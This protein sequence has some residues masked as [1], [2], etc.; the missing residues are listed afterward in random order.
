LNIDTRTHD[1]H[2]FAPCAL[3]SIDPVPMSDQSTAG[4]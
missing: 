2:S 4:E 3:L 1:V